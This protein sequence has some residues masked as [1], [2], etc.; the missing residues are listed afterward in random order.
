MMWSSYEALCELGAGDDLLDPVEIFGVCPNALT[1]PTEE[2]PVAAQSSTQ[3][4]PPRE[5][6]GVLTPTFGGGLQPTPVDSAAASAGARPMD[7]TTPMSTTS[8][9][10]FLPKA[11]LFPP[12]AGS[13]ARNSSKPPRPTSFFE[14]PNLTPIPTEKSMMSAAGFVNPVVVKRANRVASRLYYPPSPETAS[15]SSSNKPRSLFLGGLGGDNS[16]ASTRRSS[17]G[18]SKEHRM[19]ETTPKAPSQEGS[20]GGATLFAPVAER[21]TETGSSSTAAFPESTEALEIDED[22]VKSILELLCILG[23]AHKQL[24]QVRIMQLGFRHVWD[25]WSC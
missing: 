12:S 7:L 17:L 18:L 22:S 24:C 9:S 15:P 19:M 3:M 8:S 5:E 13:V 1:L 20:R 14:T 4:P 11:S 16:M 10:S 21:S 6:R 23:A 2:S 25:S